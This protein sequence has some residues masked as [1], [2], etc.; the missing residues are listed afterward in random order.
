MWWRWWKRRRWRPRRRWRR[1]RRRRAA[2]RRRR[3]PAARTRRRRVRRWRRRRRGWARRI[4][5]RKRRRLKRRKKIPITQW[6]PSTVKKCVVRGY[7]PLLICGTGTTGTTYRNYGSHQAD[8][9][10]FDP[11]GGGI[12]TLQFSLQFLYEEY[13]KH[14]NTWSRSNVDLELIRYKGASIKLYRHPEADFFFT[15]NRKPPFTDS[16]LTGPYLHP[17]NMMLRKRKI[18]VPSYKTKPKGRPTKTVRI[19]P[20]TLFTDKWYFQKDLCKAPL[21]TV[22]CSIGNLRFPFCRPQTENC[23]IYFQVLTERYNTMLSIQFEHCRKNY[24][25]LMSFMKTH[26]TNP[27]GTYSNYRDR[28]RVGTVFNTFRT[29]EHIKDPPVT[30]CTTDKNT[31]PSSC[32]KCNVPSKYSYSR[33]NSLWGDYIYTNQIVDDFSSN[34]HNYFKERSGSVVTASKYLNHKT[35]LFS[36]IFLSR[37]R[38]SPDFPGFYYEVIYNPMNDKGVGNKVWIDW[39]TKEDSFWV[40]S[41]Q[42]KTEIVDLPLWM[43]FNGYIDYCKKKHHDQGLDKEVRVTIICPYTQ[44]PLTNS[45]NTDMGFVP[46]DYNF[47]DGRMPDGQ[48]YIPIEYRFKWYPC[49]FHQQNFMNDMTQCGPFAYDGGI[50]SAVLTAKYKF[51]FLF[52]GNPIPQQTIKDPC[53]Q[54]DYEIPGG[55]GQPKRI[56]VENPKLLHEG[57][58]FRAWDLRRGFFG[59]RALQRMQQ[60]QITSKFITGPPKRSRLEVPAIAGES[61]PSPGKRWKPW[62]ESSETETDQTEAQSES[63]TKTPEFK[64]QLREQLKEQKQIKKQLL[65]IVKQLVKTQHH[66]QGPV[67]H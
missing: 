54:P 8:Y 16:Q 34:A 58:Y 38:L 2:P 65:S 31:T 41:S 4:Y 20:P 39:C 23:C 60:Q 27:K 50:K 47:G 52:G 26:W 17:G 10:K 44:P 61:S 35:G 66:L 49:A 25:S 12:S 14:R 22:G 56:Q 45:T 30:V 3:R 43:C 32:N 6:N 33:V 53:M 51:T 9:V 18:I 7:M 55:G 59:A 64:Q 21:L 57:Y 29:E 24:D 36:S 48:P 1:L 40:E 5:L 37:Q 28:G 19:K 15:Y 42:L 62:P 11:F 46:F 13:Q 63:E 67:I